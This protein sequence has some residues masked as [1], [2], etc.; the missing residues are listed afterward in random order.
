MNNFYNDSPAIM[1][2]GRTYSN[3]QP[4]AVINENI[5][6]RENINTNWAKFKELIN[7]SKK[8]IL[9]DAF[10]TT[11]TINFMNNMNIKDIITYTSDARPQQKILHQYTRYDMTVNNIIKDLD[12][13]KKLYVFY[14]FKG[15]G[16]KHKRECNKKGLLW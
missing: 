8:V 15:T 5:R 12:N 6:K 2:D 4:C 3:W 1:A 14:A 13:G 9:L 10:T 7:S 16:K 11:K